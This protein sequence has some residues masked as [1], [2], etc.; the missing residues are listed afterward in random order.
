MG[1]PV[2]TNDAGKNLEGDE[3]KFNLQSRVKSIKNNK[4]IMTKVLVGHSTSWVAHKS[5]N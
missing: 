2:A 1:R 5:L 3:V 4:M